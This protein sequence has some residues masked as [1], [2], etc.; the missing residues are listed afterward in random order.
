LVILANLA[1]LVWSLSGR[2]WTA[3]PVLALGG[4]PLA[5]GRYPAPGFPGLLAKWLVVLESYIYVP[6]AVIL[7]VINFIGGL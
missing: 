4:L 1:G 6:G 7:P 3:I 2:I 5:L